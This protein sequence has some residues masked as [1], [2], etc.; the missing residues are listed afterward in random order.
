MPEASASLGYGNQF[1]LTFPLFIHYGV[2]LWVPEVGAPIDPGSEAHD[3]A[4]TLFGSISKGERMRVKTRVT[5]V[6]IS[7]VSEEV[8]FFRTVEVP[9]LV[10]A[11]SAC[12]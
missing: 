10:P 6:G 1:S 3:L 9:K 12:T 2:P 11:C 5:C 4:M 8:T 7:R